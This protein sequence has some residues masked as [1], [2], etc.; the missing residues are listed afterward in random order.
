MDLTT[1]YHHNCHKIDGFNLC[2]S[3]QY[4]A[5]DARGVSLLSLI[6]ASSIP[7]ALA[8]RDMDSSTVKADDW[9]V[10]APPTTCS[11]RKVAFESEKQN[12]L[13]EVKTL[14]TVQND[15]WYSPVSRRTS[16]QLAQ[17]STTL[18]SPESSNTQASSKL[19]ARLPPLMEVMIG[20]GEHVQ[21]RI[22]GIVYTHENHDD[23][24]ES[25]LSDVSWD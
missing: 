6:N 14:S 9:R 16:T 1:S 24:D 7:L 8:A 18:L 23:D 4:A 17:A 13:K 21:S 10:I 15:T 3:H 12:E 22:A 25:V 2:D 19:P 11:S 20:E 5:H